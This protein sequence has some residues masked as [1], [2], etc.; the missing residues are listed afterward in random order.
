MK[1][2][3]NKHLSRDFGRWVHA[4]GEQ[5]CKKLAKAYEVP[6]ST[7]PMQSELTIWF[8]GKAFLDFFASSDRAKPLRNWLTKEHHL[9]RV[10]PPEIRLHFTNLVMDYRSHVQSLNIS[11]ITR[12]NRAYGCNFI[13]KIGANAGLFDDDLFC[14]GWKVLKRIGR[15]STL[16]DVTPGCEVAYAEIMASAEAILGDDYAVDGET[17]QELKSL[18]AN[19]LLE[20]KEGDDDLDVYGASIA[21]LDYRIRTLKGACAGIVHDHI[22]VVQ[23]VQKWLA[24]PQFTEKAYQL[25]QIFDS[26]Y[27]SGDAKVRARLYREIL[28][29]NPLPVIVLFCKLFL[30]GRFPLSSQRVYNSLT[31]RMASYDIKPKTVR[32]FLGF[33][34]RVLAAAHAF[35]CFE[36]S[37]NPDSITNLPVDALRQD[38]GGTYTLRWRKL[39]KG[40]FSSEEEI[41]SCRTENS[42]LTP[43]SLSMVDVFNHIVS[44][45]EPLRSEAYDKDKLFLA[46]YKNNNG[47]YGYIPSRFHPASFNRQFKAICRWA[48][49][50]RWVS[51]LKAIRGS[52]LL[53][54]GMV[55]R[56]ATSVAV[57]G[58]HTSFAMA[59]KYTYHMPEMLRR[60]QNIREFLDWFETLLTLDIEDFASKIGIDP[61][62]YDKR[63]QD[64][65]NRGFGGLHCSD[66]YAGIKPGTVQG[67]V[68]HRVDLCVSCEKRRS[69]FVMSESNLVSLL[70]W[71]VVL[72]EAEA[73]LSESDFKPWQLWLVFTRLMLDRIERK[74]EHALLFEAAQKAEKTLSNPYR[75]LIPVLDAAVLS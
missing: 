3:I 22:K 45:T 13:L 50:D 47:Q 46:N 17:K 14:P 11:N 68:C 28:D 27:G 32:Y 60:E 5:Y 31:T 23:E 58:R 41:V 74:P 52:L 7:Y 24:N 51:T 20:A 40:R 15:G 9:G 39:R 69:I 48:S 34:G 16:L 73:M 21:V 1:A 59:S 35:I 75:D 4:F 54:E 6:C 66:P 44:I 53:L 67:E 62:E 38:A 56:D 29:D 43:E 65:L 2:I 30:A 55:T 10:P 64:L 37:G 36:V 42:P 19:I 33:E 8:N 61:E 49:S 57:K 12:N 63:V 18:V 25:K 71:H 72:E 70:Q 26:E